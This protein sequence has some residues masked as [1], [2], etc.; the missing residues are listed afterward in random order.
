MCGRA[1]VWAA[2]NVFTMGVGVNNANAQNFTYLASTGMVQF[3]TI[4][5][6]G[7]TAIDDLAWSDERDALIAMT[8]KPY[9]AEVVAAVK[10]AKEQGIKVI[11]ISDSPA[12]PIIRAAD[13]GFVVASQTPQVFPSS[14]ATVAVL[15]TLLSFVY[16]VASDEIVTR[17]EKFHARRHALGIYVE[18]PE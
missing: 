13:H 7:S 17:V 14:V 12:S 15:E 4:P 1:D 3:Y 16:S 5:R 8:C 11:A 9:R 2:R 10:L 6:P 18:D